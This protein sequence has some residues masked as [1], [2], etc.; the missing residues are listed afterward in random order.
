MAGASITFRGTIRGI[1]LNDLDPD[2]ILVGANDGEKYC[3]IKITGKGK[4]Q[5]IQDKFGFGSEVVVTIGGGE[6]L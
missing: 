4:G 1:V 6:L 2:I 5:E 3:G